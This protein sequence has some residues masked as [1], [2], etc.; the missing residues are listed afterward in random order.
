VRDNDPDGWAEAV[1]FDRAI[2]HGY[3]RATTQGQALR[4]RYFLRCSCVPLD[5]VA[6][7]APTTTRA[8]RHLRLITT[9][10]THGADEDGDPDGC[11]PWSCRSGDPVTAAT[12]RDRGSIGGGS[13][14]RRECA[15]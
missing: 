11:S 7:D 2:R 6:L 3:P 14:E 4:G 15:A 5:Q 12:N 13:D 9:N 8:G 10:A 1:E